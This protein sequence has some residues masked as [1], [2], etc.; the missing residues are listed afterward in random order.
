MRYPKYDNKINE[1]KLKYVK[2]IDF[3]LKYLN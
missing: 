2:K 3:I 1:I